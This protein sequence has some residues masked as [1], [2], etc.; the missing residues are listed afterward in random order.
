MTPQLRH[1]LRVLA[2]GIALG[3]VMFVGYLLLGMIP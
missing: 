1:W 3:V 2:F